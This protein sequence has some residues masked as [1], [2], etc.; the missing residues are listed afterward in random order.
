MSPSQM[1]THQ[2]TEAICPELV[3]NQGQRGFN[4]AGI[5]LSPTFHTEGGSESLVLPLKGEIGV[6]LTVP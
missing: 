2:S 3:E 6:C 1:T 4:S 5:P